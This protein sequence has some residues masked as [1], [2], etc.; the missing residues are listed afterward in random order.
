MHIIPLDIQKGMIVMD[1]S[2]HQIGIVDDFRFRENEDHPEVDPADIDGIDRNPP[3]SII[4]DLARSF[5]PEDMP[6]A[7]RDRLLMEGYV[8]VHTT[9][10]FKTHRYVLPEQISAL[11]GKGLTLNVSRDELIRRHRFSAL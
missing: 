2:N 1:R 11:T 5:A 9:G 6:E 4:G 10:V 8:R 3:H 7:V